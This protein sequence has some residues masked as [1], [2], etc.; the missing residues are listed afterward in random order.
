MEKIAIAVV[1]LG[2][3][4]NEYKMTRH[5]L[6]FMAVDFL[7]ESLDVAVSSKRF[8]GLFREMNI[9]GKK[10]FLLKPTTFMNLSGISVK[11]LMD[12]HNIIVENLIVICDDFAIPFGT[13]RMRRSGSSGGHK[14]LESIIRENSTDQFPRIRIGIGPVPE[15]SDPADFVL[16][17]FNSSEKKH[18]EDIM[19][20]VKEILL[21]FVESGTEEAIRHCN[22]KTNR[23][24]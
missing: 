5:N 18:L 16:K 1:G 11:A 7:A 6:G 13:L 3:P 20:K 9:G 19:L 17:D 24:E 15:F 8:N 14:G 21:I 22:S 12:Y 2:N 4:G 10:I 23:V